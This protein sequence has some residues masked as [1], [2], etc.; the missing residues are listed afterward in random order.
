M[1]AAASAAEPATFASSAEGRRRFCGTCGTQ[2][3][4]WITA[5]PEIVDVNLVTLDEPAAIVPEHHI[6]TASRI[7][8]FETT[9]TLPRYPDAGAD[10]P[11]LRE[12][13]R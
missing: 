3:L 2:L 13:S 7:P 8:W 1:R 9:D 11:G 4:F 10:R 6:W 12:R 5:E